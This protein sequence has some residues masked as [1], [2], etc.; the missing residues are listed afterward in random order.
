MSFAASLLDELM[1]RDRNLH[2]SDQRHEL[3]WQDPDVCMSIVNR[4]RY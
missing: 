1:G 3:D 2:P 4:E